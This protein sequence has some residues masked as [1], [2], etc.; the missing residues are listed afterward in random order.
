M[1]NLNFILRII[2]F[3]PLKLII[4]NWKKTFW[5][6]CIII[7]ISY[8][9]LQ[10]ENIYKIQIGHLTAKKTKF[11]KNFL[12]LSF[13]HN[14]LL[15][16]KS[17]YN[18]TKNLLFTLINVCIKRWLCFF[19]SLNLFIFGLLGWVLWMNVKTHSRSTYQ[20]KFSLKSLG[21]K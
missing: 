17:N 1:A 12:Y 4:R 7:L 21:I 3:F 6:F 16:A 8:D 20:T 10:C 14:D 11:L 5:M 9:K 19:D 2:Y 18:F 15:G 13:L